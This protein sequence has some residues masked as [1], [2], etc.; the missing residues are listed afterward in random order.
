MS[1]LRRSQQRF[2]DAVL[3]GS[4][5][6]EQEVVEQGHITAKRR[7]D[8]YRNA[9]GQRLRD[10]IETDHQILGLYLGD[11][12]FN[13]MASGY[14]GAY[15]SKLPSLR[16][17][18][19]GLPK[20]L[21]QTEPFCDSPQIAEIAK[22]E[23]C[24]LTSFDATDKDRIDREALSALDANQWP[25]LK[26]EFHP[27]VSIFNCVWNSIPIWQRIKAGST[28]PAPTNEI[29]TRWLIWRNHERLTQFR[30][31]SPAEADSIS[32]LMAGGYFADMCQ[33]LLMYMDETRVS[34]QALE[35]LLLCIDEG[36]IS[37]LNMPSR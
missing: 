30:S 5:D 35:I 7:V 27:S 37:R 20:Y 14:I 25:T 26:F 12:L 34:Q 31:V 9:Y 23:R 22:F 3:A 10:C 1:R 18:C 19:D 32:C 33:G 29:Q 24:L 8:I 15:P 21:D 11:D 13:E 28:P 17:Y 2:A 6:F 36:A 16:F 4:S